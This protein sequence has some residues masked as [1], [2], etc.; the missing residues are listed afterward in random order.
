MPI[1]VVCDSGSANLCDASVNFM[2]SEDIVCVPAGPSNPKGNGTIEGAFS[3]LKQ[4]IGAIRIDTST[5]ESLAK[6]VLQTVVSVYV[7]MRNRLSLKRK[8]KSPAQYME[9]PVSETAKKDLKLKLQNRIRL[10]KDKE[11]DNQKLNRLHCLIKAMA[12]PCNRAAVKRA[13]KTITFFN[14]DAIVKSE[15]AFVK[16]V[17]RKKQRL[18]LSYFFGILKRVQQEQDD[19]A[20]QLHCRK[21]YNYNEMIRQMNEEI[22]RQNIHRPSTVQDVLNILASAVTI[23]AKKVKNMALKRAEEWIKELMDTTKYIGTLKKRFEDA[24]AVMTQVEPDVK[25]KIW[26]LVKD[27]LNQKNSGKSVTHFS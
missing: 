2:N 10:K 4:I 20:Y 13:E 11:E 26:L 27:L 1:G 6:S 8:F 14:M 3:Q 12:I 21:R 22:E 7:K 9:E 25:D 17:N 23:T 19:S 5:L 18:S 16:A 24:L 15:K